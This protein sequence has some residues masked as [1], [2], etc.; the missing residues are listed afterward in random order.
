[1]AQVARELQRHHDDVHN[2]LA[3]VTAAAASVIPGVDFA[4][5]TVASKALGVTSKGATDPAAERINEI[6]QA[7]GEGPC[8]SAL[9]DQ[10]L[11]RLDNVSGTSP[12]PA[13]SR[14]AAELGIAESISVRLYVLDH[15]LGALSLYSRTPGSLT[16]ESVEAAELYAAHAAVAL[17]AAELEANL[18]VAIDRRDVIGQAKGIVMERFKVTDAQAFSLLI[19][20]SQNTNTPLRE[21]ADKLTQTG[22]VAGLT[23]ESGKR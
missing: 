8:L 22:D 16:D 12:W 6:Q 18:T 4:C 2:T 15:V 14:A 7:L 21:V 19:R 9:W 13:Y 17:F 11:V 5:V 1:M 23:L 20:V 10:P 3:T